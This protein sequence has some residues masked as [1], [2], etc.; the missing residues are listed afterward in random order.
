VSQVRTLKQVEKATPPPPQG[1]G[2]NGNASKELVERYGFP[3]FKNEKGKISKLNE[4]FWAAYHSEKEPEMLFEADEEEFYCYDAE[5]G[6]FQP[7][8]CDSIRKNS[9]N[10]F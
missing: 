2:A 6:L 7:R 4:P 3:A 8:S 9:P 10:K 1:H 5:T